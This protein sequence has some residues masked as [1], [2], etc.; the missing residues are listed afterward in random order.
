MKLSLGIGEKVRELRKA[1][2]MTQHALA[3]RLGLSQARL[4]EIE[5]G[6]GSFSAE[7]FLLI[8]KLFNASVSDF[9]PGGVRD[10]ASQL[11]NSLVRLG[12]A[13]LH[14]VE[15]L[16][17][18]G[19]L[20]DLHKVIRDALITGSPRL[21][22]ALG[23]V[24]VQNIDL[25]NL[26]ALYQDLRRDGLERRF[27]WVIENVRDAISLQREQLSAPANRL[28]R[29][30]SFLFDEF[31]AFIA[32]VEPADASAPPDVIDRS[33]RSKKSL[34][35]VR[36]SSSESAKKWGVVTSLQLSDFTHALAGAHEAG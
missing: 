32:S 36:A 29:R 2:G 15:Q 13:Q 7:Q 30:A 8:L 22:T 27:G 3:T 28:R 9:D 26:R 14:E 24:L 1:R 11:Q 20:A 33:I 31:L 25:I 18:S 35:R 34:E 23:P 21:L 10:P 19:D 12:A 4:S 17:P 16:I 5:R 6:A